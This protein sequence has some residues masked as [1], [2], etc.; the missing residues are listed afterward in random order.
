MR[1]NVLLRSML[2]AA[3]GLALILTLIPVKAAAQAAPSAA[4]KEMMKDE[5]KKTVDSLNLT[6]DQKNKMH[7]ILGDAKTQRESIFK[8]S[9]LT[10]EQK[11]EKLKDLRTSTRS[12]IDDVLTPDQRTQ[13]TDKLKAAAAKAKSVQ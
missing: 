4:T 9:S 6:G 8:D 13:L 2:S 5:F 3:T 11:Q 1:C 7:G 10:D 12:K